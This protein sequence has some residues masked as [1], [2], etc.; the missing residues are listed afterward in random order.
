MRINVY[1]IL[2]SLKRIKEILQVILEAPQLPTKLLMT[3]LRL[4]VR[5][6]YQ[7]KIKILLNSRRKVCNPL[8]S[9]A[10]YYP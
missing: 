5:F 6:V 8:T 4:T 9:T 10:N 2:Q 1:E 7:V 3:T